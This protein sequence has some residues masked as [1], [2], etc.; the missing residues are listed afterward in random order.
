MKAYKIKIVGDVQGV[1]YRFS[2]IREAQSLG[3]SGWV[4]NDPDGG[5]SA[6]IQG[7]EESCS[8]FIEWA[9]EG[10]PMAE[11]EKAEGEETE[12]DEGL[13]GFNVK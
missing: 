6:Q 5:V 10:S 7:D 11:V 3:L 1:G 4:K 13:R 8:Q 2:A 9:R 12:I